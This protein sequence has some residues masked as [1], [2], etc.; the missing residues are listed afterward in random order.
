MLVNIT[1]QY[2]WSVLHPTVQPHSDP[3]SFHCKRS[4]LYV[5][6]FS[7]QTAIELQMQQ[8]PYWRKLSNISSH[9]W[10]KTGKGNK[11]ELTNPDN[12]Q[13]FTGI[14][15]YL[16]SSL[17]PYE[18]LSQSNVNLPN[19]F[20]SSWFLKSSSADAGFT[21]QWIESGTNNTNVK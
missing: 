6:I 17:S 15:V 1:I 10:V 13:I 8:L 7:I 19:S 14:L 9:D 2:F 21:A 4:N 11:T 16:N 12:P 18:L 3:N 5:N 20:I